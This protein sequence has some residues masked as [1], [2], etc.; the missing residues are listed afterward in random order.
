MARPSQRTRTC[1]GVMARTASALVTLEK[2]MRWIMG[3]QQLWMLE[4][5][6]QNQDEEQ[7]VARKVKSA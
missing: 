4:A 6:L 1:S 5:K 7:T 3:H 2:R